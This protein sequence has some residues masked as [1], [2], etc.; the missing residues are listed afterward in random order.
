MNLIRV[1]GGGIYEPEYFYSLCDELGL[2]VWQDHLMAC[3]AYPAVPEF[4]RELEA[5]IT[6]NVRRLHA[7]PSIVLWCGDN[8]GE[9]ANVRWF[10][11]SPNHRHMLRSYYRLMEGT[12]AKVTRREDP[13]RPFRLSSPS[14]GNHKDPGLHDR[15]D[16]H[17]WDVWMGDLPFARHLEA[18]PRFASEFGYESFPHARTLREALRG[19]ELNPVSAEAEFH[20][21]FPGG[22]V[23]ITN[24]LA[25]WFR[26]PADFDS[27]C[28]VS[29]LLSGVCVKLAVEHWR[30]IKPHCQGTI[31]WQLADTWPV[32]SHAS[33][34]SS[35]EWKALHYFAKRF[36][37]P[38]LASLHPMKLNER[39][40]VEAWLTSDL[41]E[42]V[43]G[44]WTLELCGLD[45]SKRRVAGGEFRLRADE[46]RRIA[47]F[48]ALELSPG[49]L[50]EQ[51]FLVLRARA[52]KYRSENFHFFAPFKWLELP[53]ARVKV[54]ARKSADNGLR[55]KVSTD[56]PAL[57]VELVSAKVPGVFSD[58]Y[59]HLLAGESRE[60][61][62]F[63]RE[64]AGEAS[65]ARFRA[66]VEL[67][68]L[69]G[70]Y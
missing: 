24:M 45:G 28:Y 44:R 43:A 23:K 18:R 21:R 38:L 59:F 49:Y 34:D 52:G 58:N 19:P 53:K 11:E 64:D 3:S 39:C 68:S 56:A 37:S 50:P 41:N 42:A 62:F 12:V 65:L 57:F 2:M 25:K 9:V 70:S 55:V 22:N 29:Q 30:R 54:R 8:E 61:K 48:K 15:G 14:S 17:V 31:Y 13:D 6:H 4:A 51:R 27:F 35:R 67:R 20:E 69:V 26:L 47:T 16:A 46:S 5:E 60:V 63:P 7:H 1:W 66:G 36:Y 33:I 10:R 32:V 40:D